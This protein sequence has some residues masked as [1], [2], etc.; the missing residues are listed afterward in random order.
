MNK[1]MLAKCEG[2]VVRIRPIARRF[3]GQQELEPLDDDWRIG[4]V[5]LARKT[6]EIRNVRCDQCPTLG[7]DHI[8][9]YSSDPMRDF[10]GQKH[11]FLQLNVQVFL[12]EQGPHV[13]PLPPSFR[14]DEGPPRA[15]RPLLSD[16]A[17]KLL[18]EAAQDPEGAV[19]RLGTFGGTF[20][21][22]NGR[23][24]V[25]DN[26]PRAAS[27]WRG[28]VDELYR[29]RLLED[30]SGRGEVFFL[31]AEGYAIADLA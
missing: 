27:R 25:E 23:N 30:R 24:L 18:R 17:R 9:S 12:T 14:R 22:T 19:I 28:A 13:E 15:T 21:K 3:Q 1:E 10:D 20:V 29:L 26:S 11:A 8:H 31:T 4:R 5:D 2:Y 6:L 16:T 7:L